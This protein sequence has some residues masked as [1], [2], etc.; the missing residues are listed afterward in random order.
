MATEATDGLV[1]LHVPP[2][3]PL[4]NRLDSPVHIKSDVPK[5]GA[6]CGFTV[7]IPTEEHPVGS[8]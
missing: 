8:V 5:I 4:V 1:L 7:A 2:A 3:E 6:G